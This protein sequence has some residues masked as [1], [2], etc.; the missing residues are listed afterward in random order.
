[1]GGGGGRQREQLPAVF[2]PVQ[3]SG[4]W[5]DRPACLLPTPV[6]GLVSVVTSLSFVM[7][8]QGTFATLLFFLGCEG[9]TGFL[10]RVPKSGK[11]TKIKYS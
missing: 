6:F 3:T 11:E 4:W 2:S 10:G 1:M 5:G 9:Q 8:V 7:L